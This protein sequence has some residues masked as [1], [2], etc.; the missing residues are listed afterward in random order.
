MCM[1]DVYSEALPDLSPEWRTQAQCEQ[2]LSVS[3]NG[4][5]NI[6]VTL[7]TKFAVI[8]NTVGIW[9]QT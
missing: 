8:C 4:T 9:R 1:L 7:C 2:N 5:E 6:D 3:L